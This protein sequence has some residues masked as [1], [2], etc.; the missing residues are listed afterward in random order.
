MKLLS[1][2]VESIVGSVSYEG[3]MFYF[4]TN[5]SVAKRIVDKRP[6]T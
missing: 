4:E 2:E 6:K 5:P 3:L 1:P